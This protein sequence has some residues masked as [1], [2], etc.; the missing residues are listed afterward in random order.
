M[1]TRRSKRKK[2]LAIA[3]IALGVIIMAASLSI[4][5][6]GY[7]ARG[8]YGMYDPGMY[9]MY[10]AGMYGPGMY[11][12]PYRQ[13][14]H[15]MTGNGSIW[16]AWSG[17]YGMPY[18]GAMMFDSNLMP[19]LDTM[20]GLDLTQDQR[21]RIDAIESQAGEKRLDLLDSLNAENGKLNALFLG[22]G[23]DADALKEQYARCAQL[24]RRIFEL[25][26][27]ERKQLD[28]V[29]SDDQRRQWHRWQR[30]YLMQ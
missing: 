21:A 1:P 30:A 17:M 6:P 9:G 22:E 12:Q 25:G 18:P 4:G 3:M 29:L 28:A 26:L 7:Y 13:Y 16:G 5:R 15:H 10:G 14:G 24:R 27:N 19:D 2:W 20:Q 23:V 11:A 8:M